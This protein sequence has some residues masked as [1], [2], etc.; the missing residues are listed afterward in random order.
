MEDG[1]SKFERS[2]T[3]GIR[4]KTY[5]S[6]VDPKLLSVLLYGAMTGL[7]VQ[8]AACPE[9]VTPDRAVEAS[10]L[11]VRLLAD[12]PEVTRQRD[13]RKSAHGEA[14][15]ERLE[16]Q[17]LEDPALAPPA[18]MALASA[19]RAMYQSFVSRPSAGGQ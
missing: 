13:R 11:L 12:R 14:I 3:A 6:D 17:L 19:F 7:A 16:S 2:L 9:H 18:A 4:S 1:R 10:L 8:A 15:A 5:R